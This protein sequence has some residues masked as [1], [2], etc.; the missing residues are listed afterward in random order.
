M[1]LLAFWDL[2][3]GWRSALC[4]GTSKVPSCRGERSTPPI[5]GDCRYLRL[6][7]PV[8]VT[9]TPHKETSTFDGHLSSCS[10]AMTIINKTSTLVKLTLF[11]HRKPSL[12]VQESEHYWQNEHPKAL[13]AYNDKIGRPIV[14]YIQCHRNDRDVKQGQGEMRDVFGESHLDEGYEAVV[15]VWFNRYVQYGRG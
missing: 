11:V 14:R 1:T 5:L 2:G 9:D 10:T 8:P 4:Q 12:S 6:E 13:A 15:E 7:S 3:T